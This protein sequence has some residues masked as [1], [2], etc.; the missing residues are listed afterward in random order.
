LDYYRRTA[1]EFI[2]NSSVLGAQ[3]TILAG[4]RYDGLA[5]TL[6]GAHT[7]GVGWGSG[8]ERLMLALEAE[9]RSVP[10]PESTLAYVV[11]MDEDSLS[12]A[13]S[14]AREARSAGKVLAAY[15]VKGMGKAFADAEKFG[16]RFAVIVGSEERASDVLS[17]RD[18]ATREQHRVERAQLLDWLTAR[19]TPGAITP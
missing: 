2:H 11:P 17:V 7:P 4:G 19:Q 12:Y 5:E 15:K 8:V 9:Q 3:S 6:G 14:V 1:F 18:M 16:S 10:L 13:H